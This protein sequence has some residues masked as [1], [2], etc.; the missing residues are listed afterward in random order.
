[1]N[2]TLEPVK[3]I[4]LPNVGGPHP[5]RWRLDWTAMADLEGT[6]TA[7]LTSAFSFL[8][9]QTETSA[10]LGS[11]TCQCFEWNLHHQLSWVSSSPTADLTDF[12][13]DKGVS[14]YLIINL[15]LNIYIW[16]LLVL[17]LWRTL[18]TTTN[19]NIYYIFLIPKNHLRPNKIQQQNGQSIQIDNHIRN[20]SINSDQPHK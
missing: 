20:M 15:F 5:V 7:C 16:I 2:L 6:L 14:Q 18:T 11:H 1:M 8:W 3:Q 9:T 17:F 13:K 10:L 12:A 4:G 19:L